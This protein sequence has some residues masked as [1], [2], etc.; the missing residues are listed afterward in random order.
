LLVSP[1]ALP[2]RIKPDPYNPRLCLDP[3]CKLAEPEAR[4]FAHLLWLYALR[5]MPGGNHRAQR[6]G[7]PRVRPSRLCVRWFFL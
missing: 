1:G 6:G 2:F 7:K 5:A 3:A 4:L